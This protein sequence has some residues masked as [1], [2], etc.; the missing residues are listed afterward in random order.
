MKTQVLEE[1][2]SVQ[3]PLEKYRLLYAIYVSAQY[4]TDEENQ[5][6]PYVYDKMYKRFENQVKELESLESKESKNK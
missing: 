4:I 6:I 3:I 2:I 5:K 1:P